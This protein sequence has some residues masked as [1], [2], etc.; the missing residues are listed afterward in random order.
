M[1]LPE[2]IKVRKKVSQKISHISFFIISGHCY[3]LQAFAKL[4]RNLINTL[5]RDTELLKSVLL[6]HVVPRKLFSRNFNHDITLK[7]AL[8]DDQDEGKA[9][10]IYEKTS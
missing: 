2:K 4:D 7:T 8:I 6:Y 5:T 1:N 3:F 9:G 10:K